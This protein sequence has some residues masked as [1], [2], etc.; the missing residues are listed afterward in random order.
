MAVPL[1]AAAV[2]ATATSKTGKRVIKAGCL[3]VFGMFL[4]F[5]L[6]IAAVVGVVGTQ[7][8]QAACG[9]SAAAG[10]TSTQP[11]GGAL[12]NIKIIVGVAKAR[13]IGIPGQII[14]VGVAKVESSW[15][16]LANPAVPETM[17]DPHK[18]GVGF[19]HFS[20]GIMQQQT[21]PFGNYWGTPAQ[22]MDPAYAAGRFYTELL[23]KVPNYASIPMG[24]AAQTVQVSAFPDRYQAEQGL[25]TQLV[26]ANQDA[27]PIQTSGPTAG[28]GAPCG[29]G[30]T[31]SILA[32][33]N[34]LDALNLPY[35]FGGGHTGTPAV[36][37]VGIRDCVLPT[38]GLDCSGA[39]SY[40]LQHAAVL[41]KGGGV[42]PTMTSSQFETR[43]D[44]VPGPVWAPHPTGVYIYASADHMFMTINGRVFSSD[45]SSIRS[46]GPHWRTWT[47]A[48]EWTGQAAPPVV[49]H[50]PGT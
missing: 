26:N 46:G 9:A 8:A 22:V 20:A 35:C 10:G 47:P 43:G 5:M 6:I 48:E 23:N 34:A 2:K 32:A 24:V 29:S 45:T 13:N 3:A 42:V 39:V 49:R 38:V 7:Q 27:P 12:D 19:D 40:V 1:V 31:A 50:V 16:S 15:L 14:A 36:P 28:G 44:P 37:S 41:A 4:M 33:A 18:Q 30:D 25:A 11:S 21:G 17:T